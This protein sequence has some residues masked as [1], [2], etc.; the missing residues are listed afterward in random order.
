MTRKIRLPSPTWLCV[1]IVMSLLAFTLLFVLVYFLIQLGYMEMR[2]AIVLGVIFAT[3]VMILVL[4]N[5]LLWNAPLTLS[6]EGIRKRNKVLR[7]E[8]AVSVLPNKK[9]IFKTLRIKYSDGRSI[10]LEARKPYL[11]SIE[12]T[13]GNREFL[14]MFWAASLELEKNS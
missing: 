14:T 6:E 12:D 11:K 7:W 9:G 2:I 10:V 3:Q 8:D 13:C 1:Q 5:A 4:F